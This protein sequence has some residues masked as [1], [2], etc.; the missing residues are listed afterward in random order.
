MQNGSSRTPPSLNI[1]NSNTTASSSRPTLK[2]NT[3][4]VR[5]LSDL[6]ISGLSTPQHHGQYSRRPSNRS[7]QRHGKQSRHNQGPGHSSPLSGNG[8]PQVPTIDEQPEV[9]LETVWKSNLAYTRSH[10][11]LLK[12]RGL[13][14]TNAP[15][16]NRGLD[17]EEGGESGRITIV[18]TSM[19][20]R[21]ASVADTRTDASVSVERMFESGGNGRQEYRRPVC[22]RRATIGKACDSLPSLGS[23]MEVVTRKDGERNSLD[24]RQVSGQFQPGPSS[25][26]EES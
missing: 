3:S 17:E 12:L 25:L 7:S 6:G 13:N 23:V 19:R 9:D 21:A 10:A 14:Q 15:G 18:T 4:I 11:D 1:D 16:Y 2:R 26:V 20:R 24:Q 8:Q 5:S 22:Q